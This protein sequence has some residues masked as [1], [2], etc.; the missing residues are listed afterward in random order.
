MVIIT[1]RK[2]KEDEVEIVLAML[3]DAAVWLKSKKIDYWQNWA[4]PGENYIGWIREGVVNGEFHFAEIDGEIAGVYRLQFSDEMF[5]GKM[6]DKAGYIHS[7]TTKRAFSGKGYGSE[8]L[9]IIEDKLRRCGIK[10]MRLDCGA[11]IEGLCKYYEHHDFT[12]LYER[13]VF[14]FKAAFYEKRI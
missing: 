6:E 11:E 3:K 9:K 8:I 10:Y 5:W 2:V 14:G 13:E 7:F 4:A 12:K 1:E